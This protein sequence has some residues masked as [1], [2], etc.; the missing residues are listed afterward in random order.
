M[1]RSRIHLIFFIEFSSSLTSEWPLS[2]TSDIV[3]QIGMTDIFMAGSALI[4][5][6]AQEIIAVGNK[7]FI[8]CHGG[9][10][11]VGVTA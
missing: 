9:F 10:L 1:D 11:Q 7:S 4:V 3:A 2:P 5:G 6:G 8:G